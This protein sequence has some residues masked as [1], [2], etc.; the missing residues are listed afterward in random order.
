MNPFSELRTEMRRL[1]SQTVEATEKRGEVFTPWSV[2]EQMA[3]QLGPWGDPD[4]TFF[5]PTANLG[6]MSCVIGGRL[7]DGL[8]AAITDPAA[9]LRNI[10][11]R[12]LFM[13]EFDP[14]VA[15]EAARLPAISRSDGS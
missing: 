11:E 2:I 12:Q 4:R 15:A 9:R 3:D 8:A 13:S 7:W 14:A 5:D 6:Q 1:A 10:V